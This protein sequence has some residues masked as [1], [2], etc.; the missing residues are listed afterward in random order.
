MT[1]KKNHILMILSAA[2]ATLHFVLSPFAARAQDRDFTRV[3]PPSEYPFTFIYGMT[4]DIHGFMWII[5]SQQLYKY[6]G[7]NFI[8]YQHDPSNPNSMAGIR[9]E[10]IFADQTGLIWI[11]HSAAG[12]DCLD[13]ATGIFTHYRHIAND[14]ESLSSD[15]VLSV[16]RDHN[17]DIWAGTTKGLNKLDV[18][19]GKFVHYMNNTN[20]PGSLS[21][22]NVRVLL[23]DKSG[24]LWAGTGNAWYGSGQGKRGGLNRFI[25]SS[26]KF[27]H[28]MHDPDDTAT[29]IDNRVNAICE[30]SR[31]LL[32]VGTAGDGLHTLDRETGRVHRHQFDPGHP[33]KLSRPP[34]K[35]FPYGADDYITFIKEDAAGNIW[36]GTL[37]S[38][39]NRYNPKADTVEHFESLVRNENDEKTIGYF[40]A[41][42]SVK[43]GELWISSFPR[44]LF[45]LDPFRI[46]PPHNNTHQTAFHCFL[47]DSTNQFWLGSARGLWLG[48]PGVDKAAVKFTH[49][50]KD[51]SSISSSNIHCLL[52]YN[53][54][55][56]WI[57]TDSGL[58]YFDYDKKSFRCYRN[59]PGQ[60]HSISNDS[61]YCMHRDQKGNMWI[62][63]ANGLNR[64]DNEGDSFTSFDCIPNKTD[65]PRSKFIKCILE[66][67]SHQIWLGTWWGGG[68]KLFDPATGKCKQ[69]LKGSYIT[70]LLEDSYG[71]I[72]VGTNTSIFSYNRQIDSFEKFSDENVLF[73][74]L[75]VNYLVEDEKKNLWVSS[76]SGFLKIDSTRTESIRY[77]GRQGMDITDLFEYGGYKDGNRKIYIG[78]NHGYYAFSPDEL[79]TNPYPPSIVISSIKLEHGSIAAGEKDFNSVPVADSENISLK[80]NQN[81]FSFEFNVLHYGRPEY[82]KV[83]YKLD[84]Y[85]RDWH[86]ANNERT[87]SFF[88]LSPGSYQ[89]IVR[90]RS[91]NGVWAQKS[92]SITI[93][94]IWWKSWWFKIVLTLLAV[95]AFYRIIRW[96][97]HQNFRRKLDRIEEERQLADLQHKTA[98]LE[99]Q[100]LRT[101]MN[102]HFIFNSL[103]SINRFILQNN[104]GQASQYLT[105]FSKLIRLILQNSQADLISL[106]SELDSLELYLDLESLR[107]D[108]HFNYKISVEND[109]DLSNINVPPLIIQPY[110]ENA[111]WHGL[112]HKEEKGQ[113][114]IDISVND[115]HLV[116]RVTD[117]GIGRKKAEELGSKSATRHKS[118]GL[119]ITAD[120]IALIQK[121][122][123]KGPA[124]KILDLSNPDGSAAGTEVT[125]SLPLIYG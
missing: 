96:S 62:G 72:W 124:V 80:S 59:V 102:P 37:A 49:D 61:I 18:K 98:I 69:Y 93:H 10:C 122:E 94:P 33:G 27:F 104:K 42:S 2:L 113:L 55:S 114:D 15:E 76:F 73:D 95:A 58:N 101:Q 84:N 16:L 115:N 13:P 106:E 75:Y 125:I 43:D 28:Y 1:L 100:V 86:F 112:M 17:G 90:A 8:V 46:S 91:S 57:G 26:G 32:W 118:M 54:N 23:E 38:G 52:Q 5:A 20:D 44:D 88:D 68:V 81:S 120:R 47:R 108:Y 116:C 14:P 117:N 35:F 85:E 92:I 97:L 78:D 66:D 11:G 64:L 50:S 87:A 119:H 56:L 31:G 109:V 60:A 29:L 82:N 24:T 6:D 105:K 67:K 39:M 110:V 70:C 123:E 77:S 7:Y 53:K 48:E 40:Q 107:F 3:L 36:I 121:E 30:D 34:Q 12:L 103:N 9:P 25:P 22:D 19:S 79:V 41:Y 89:F 99:M 83:Y 45:R 74:N 4:Q 51:K 71:I 63:T 111:I 21:S 65:D